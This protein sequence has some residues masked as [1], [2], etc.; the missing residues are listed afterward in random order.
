MKHTT[1][2]LNLLTPETRHIDEMRLKRR[3]NIIS[4]NWA[5]LRLTGDVEVAGGSWDLS[6]RTLLC[7]NSTWIPCRCIL[8]QKTK[9]DLG[10]RWVAW[11]G[12]D[13][14]ICLNLCFQNKANKLFSKF[15]GFSANAHF[16][17]LQEETRHTT[18]I[19]FIFICML[20]KLGVICYITIFR[21]TSRHAVHARC[22]SA[23]KHYLQSTFVTLNTFLVFEKTTK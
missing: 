4:K 14:R 6:S 8:W 5:I 11:Q 1:T 20:S 9:H 12:W 2:W 21:E 10:F 18:S 23:Q 7:C 16:G 3:W 13:I 22:F 19:I 17:A 15:D